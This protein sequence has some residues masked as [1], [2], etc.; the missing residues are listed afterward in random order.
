MATVRI[1]YRKE[2]FRDF[3]LKPACTGAGL[4][5]VQIFRGVIIW[6]EF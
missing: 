2:G 6:L 4:F 1:F 5:F 3:T